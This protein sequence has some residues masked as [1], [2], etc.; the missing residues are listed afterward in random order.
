MSNKQRL[1]KLEKKMKVGEKTMKWYS[2][3]LENG[4]Y[5]TDDHQVLTKDTE[6]NLLFENGEVFYDNSNENISLII[7]EFV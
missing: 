2:V 6:G 4:I 1:E 7:R 5:T 3:F